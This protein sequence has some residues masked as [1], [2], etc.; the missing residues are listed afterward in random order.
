MNGTLLASTIASAPSAGLAPH[1]PAS[2]LS[3]VNNVT[4]FTKH[5]N[6]FKFEVGIVDTSHPN[7]AAIE[8]VSFST[9]V[10]G[11]GRFEGAT[12]TTSSRAR[13]TSPDFLTFEGEDTGEICLPAL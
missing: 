9:V 12:G 2:T 5:G 4:V 13:Y 1:V 7:T 3:F 11:T 6:L 8:F 10:G